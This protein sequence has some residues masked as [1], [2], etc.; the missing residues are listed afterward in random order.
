MDCGSGQLALE[1]IAADQI[2]PNPWNPNRM[3]RDKMGKLKAEIRRRGFGAPILVRPAE[4]RYQIVDGE[5]RWRIARELRI[6]MIPC[7]V[8]EMDPMTARIKTIQMNGFRGENDPGRLA[9][10]LSE[11]SMAFGS[12]KLSSLLPWSEM[13]IGQMISLAAKQAES[14]VLTEIEA[15]TMEPLEFELFTAVVTIAHKGVIEKS[16]SKAKQILGIDESGSALAEICSQYLHNFRPPE[17]P[18][19]ESAERK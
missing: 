8:T 10:L 4:G 5:H 13:E 12:Q 11:L 6:P 15:L 7:V 17:P 2:A 16:L 1:W 19:K 14:E 9:T 18:G 3:S